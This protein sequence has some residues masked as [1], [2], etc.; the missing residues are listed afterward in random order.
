MGKVQEY[1][2]KLA[3]VLEYLSDHN[4]D[5][6]VLNRADNFAWF[7]CGADS[8]VNAAEESGVGTFV[9]TPEQVTLVSKNIETERLL[10][11]ELS[12]LSP[13]KSV[14]YPWHK[15]EQREEEIADLIDSGSFAADDGSCDL[16]PLPADWN[17][18]RYQLTDTEIRRYR[19]L[20]QDASEAMEAAAKSVEKGMSERRISG[21]VAHQYRS[22]GLFPA[23]LLVAADDRIREWRHPVPK[24]LDVE[25][26]VMLVACGRRRGLVTAITRFVHFGALSDDLKE[27][28]EA[29]CTVDGE[30][31][32]ATRPGSTAAD[33]IKAAQSAYAEVGYPEE[34][35]LH[36][37]GGAIGYQPREY[38]ADP[39]CAHRIR[40]KQAFAWNPSICGTKSEDTIL[41]TDDGP[42]LLTQ[43]SEDWPTIDVEVNGKTVPRADMLVR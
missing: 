35:K 32:A 13:L 2:V 19:K 12:G 36:H 6:V 28:H 8:V 9:V 25:Q 7:G 42:E 17:E 22:R 39:T 26:Y 38:I 33:A 10:T 3:R 14:T 41:V 11:E 31:M 4:L 34:W 24:N 40:D 21:L 20:G 16:P 5:G 15:P 29:V 43:P 30:I 27:R 23:V 37:Q 1:E 18:L